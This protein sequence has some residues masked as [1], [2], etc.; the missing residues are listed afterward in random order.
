LYFLD[1]IR[2]T[3]SHSRC[4]FPSSSFF[5]FFHGYEEIK[6][7]LASYELASRLFLLL[8]E[9]AL[10]LVEPCNSSGPVSF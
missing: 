6:E 10:Q 1:L 7:W 2:A 8:E 4:F 3:K 9:E 5:F